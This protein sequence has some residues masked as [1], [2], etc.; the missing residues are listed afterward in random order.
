MTALLVS[1]AG[2]IG[3]MVR[4]LVDGS[5]RERFNGSFPIATLLIN[6]SGS[7]ILGLLTGLVSNHLMSTEIKLVLGT[8]F[9][10]GYTTFSTAN[11]ET[12]RLAQSP[13][14][15]LTFI[16][17]FG[18]VLLTLIAAIAGIEIA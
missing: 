4:F 11:F 15:Y 8:G 17:V 12:I 7:F 9:C 14:H 16:N 2:A 5:I 3:A 1:I 13:N 6:V 18:T 10:G